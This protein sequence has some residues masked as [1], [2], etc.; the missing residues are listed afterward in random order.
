M[1]KL[2]MMALRDDT[3]AL[4][5]VAQSSLLSRSVRE[6]TA[7][8]RAWISLRLLTADCWTGFF[9][10]SGEADHWQTTGSKPACQWGMLN[11]WWSFGYAIDGRLINIVSNGLRRFK[12][13]AGVINAQSQ[14][15]NRTIYERLLGF[16]SSATTFLAPKFLVASTVSDGD[17]LRLI[18]TA[19]FEGGN[20]AGLF[21][22][23]SVLLA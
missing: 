6:V 1:L 8:R 19:R 14:A 10:A 17:G 15:I 9:C 4:V 16:I 3:L 7:L 12:A 18:F 23:L 13:W 22:A 21:W 2:K 5:V 20:V 11:C